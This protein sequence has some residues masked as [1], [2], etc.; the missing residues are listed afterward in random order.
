MKFYKCLECN[1]IFSETKTV[2]EDLTPG[3]AFEGGSFVNHYEVCPYC[4]ENNYKE[5]EEC[6]RCGFIEIKEN[7]E[8]IKGQFICEHCLKLMEEE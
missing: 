7:G 5:L 4:E 3:G 2:S 1:R 8:K 6:D